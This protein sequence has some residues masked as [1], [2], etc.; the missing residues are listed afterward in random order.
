MA[1]LILLGAACATSGRELRPPGVFAPVVQR[2][3]S[4]EFAGLSLDAAGQFNEIHSARGG[5]VTPTLSWGKIPKEA[6][7]LVL[8]VDAPKPDLGTD[9]RSVVWFVA[10]IPVTTTGT[11]PTLAVPGEQFIA[12]RGPTTA[13]GSRQNIRFRLWAAR[14]KFTNPAESPLQIVLR[15]DKQNVG[16][17]EFSCPFAPK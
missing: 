14:E 15:L 8:V 16:K 10:N 5:N 12:W 6:A 7:Y 3:G 11:D 1:P 17:A 9:D 4:I 13:V 2:S